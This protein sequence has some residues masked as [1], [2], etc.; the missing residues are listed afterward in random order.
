MNRVLHR[1]YGCEPKMIRI[2]EPLPSDDGP[3]DYCGRFDA[4]TMFEFTSRL[5][6]DAE[7]QFA[8][9]RWYDPTVGR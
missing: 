4:D 9:A 2:A 7:L 3:Y 5:D 1:N 8:P 6:A